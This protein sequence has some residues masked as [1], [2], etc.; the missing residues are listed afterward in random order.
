MPAILLLAGVAM[1]HA[2]PPR[3]PMAQIARVEQAP[4]VDGQGD[5]PAWLHTVAIQDFQTLGA[6]APAEA[7]TTVRFA[8]DARHL[9][10]YARCEEPLLKVAT[11]RTHEVRM[12]AKEQDANVFND[13]SL[14]IIF[15]LPERDENYE[16]AV[17]PLGTVADARSTGNSLWTGRDFAWNSGAKAAATIHDG[18]WEVEI[19]IPWSS[20]PGGM[21]SVGDT[22]EVVL[23]R[24]ARGREEFSSWNPSGMAG[25]HTPEG[26]GKLVFGELLPGMQQANRLK[27][28]APGRNAMELV[29]EPNRKAP[30]Q[31]KTSYRSFGK[32]ELS[33]VATKVEGSTPIRQVCP[34]EVAEPGIKPFAYSVRD[35]ASLHPLYISPTINLKAVESFSEL[36]LSVPGRY[37]VFVNGE[38]V[39]EGTDAKEASVRLPLARGANTLTVR[40]EEGVAKLQLK[41]EGRARWRYRAGTATDAEIATGN[42]KGWEW[43]PTAED[44]TLGTAGKPAIFRHTL[45]HGY[46]RLWPLQQPAVYLAAEIPQFLTFTA[47]GLP[48]DTLNGWQAELK[49]PSFITVR[50]ATGFYAKNNPGK[51][52][53][54][55]QKVGEDERTTRYRITTDAPLPDRS[56]QHPL[57]QIFQL[58]LIA[59]EVP[60]DGRHLLELSSVA[61]DGAVSETLQQWELRFLPKPEGRQPKK[62]VWLLWGGALG[63]TDLPSF[64]QDVL[65]AAQ[66]VGFNEITSGDPET[67]EMGPR[68]GIRNHVDL[69]FKEARLDLGAYLNERPE[70]RLVTRDGTPSKILMCTSHLLGEGW[71]A[72]ADVIR[73]F[74]TQRKVQ[75]A[76]YDYEYGPFAGPHSCYCPQCLAEFRTIAGISAET[77]LT[78]ETIRQSH[79]ATWTDFMAKRVAKIFRKM[80]EVVNALPEA[81]TFSVYSGYQTEDNPLRYGVDWRY[82]AEENA[83]DWM[84]CGYGRPVEAIRRTLEASRGTPVVTGELLVPYLTRE[85]LN[86]DTPVTPTTKARLLRLML[87]GSGGILVYERNSLDGRSWWA[88]GEVSRLVAEEEALFLERRLEAVKGVSEASGQL[89]RGDKHALLVLMNPGTSE[90]SFTFELPKEFNEGREFY[91][92]TT[93]KAGE[94]I[95]LKLP[96]GEAAVYRLAKAENKGGAK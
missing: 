31:L 20:F 29:F 96:P 66:A 73:A 59:R 92:G 76:S 79:A 37:A 16:L 41:H 6:Y 68:Y 13:D 51:A 12:A 24:V 72:A 56:R 34:V 91:N 63:A 89:L 61:N 94:R 52:R 53:F 70:A 43:A 48:G 62:L 5:D 67:S 88:L 18:H 71:T 49:V 54:A 10:L 11:Q 1:T 25:L 42:D 87:D 2:T 90:A 3:Q 82:V 78:P 50:E 27:E 17:N 58:S 75:A 33:H 28:L 14:L 93:L 74:M 85:N 45:L 64:R 95:T 55:V 80:R 8:Y 60:K 26:F 77:I 47:T 57:F 40:A 32:E 44:G 65:E 69:Y 30:M 46:T 23:A 35:A 21:P 84:A 83:A 4:K 86:R 9:Y 36:Q 19:A 7:D 15:R 39:A 81:P 22:W 38:K